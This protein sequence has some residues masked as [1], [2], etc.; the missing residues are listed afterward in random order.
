M[1]NENKIFIIAEAGVNHNGDINLAY[2]LVDNA[3]N[4]GADA[5]K[6]QT[7]KSANLASKFAEKADYQNNN[8][9]SHSQLE[10]LKKLELSFNEFEKLKN[11]CFDKKIIF[12]STP[13]DNESIE[14]LA[15]LD[16]EIFKIPS[17]EL[18]NLPYLRK[19]N[20][21]KKEVI[22]STG[23]ADIKEIEEALKA[24]SLCKKISLLH[25][26]TSYPTPFEHVNLNAMFSLKEMFRL[27]VGYSDHT[28]GIVIPIAAAALGAQIIEK[29]F[30]L[31]KNMEGPDHKASLNPKELYDMVKA[32]RNVE[33]ALGSFEKKITPIE[34][35]NKL[36]ARKSIVAS[37]NILKGE[38]FSE[39]NICAKR[40]GT[41][42][43]PMFWDSVIGKESKRNYYTDE[44]IIDE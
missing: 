35:D 40:P 41:G 39:E 14:Y 32:V 29:H 17:G 5:V 34:I 9:N 13:F 23:M 24:L 10:M 30:T 1:N 21:L 19:I 44:L 20:L 36:V 7:F 6:F 12:M 27:P 42:I 25:C 3:K 33:K 4:A 11:Y 18:T 15:S 8:E 28:K 2:K 43:S 37:K 22:V 38:R 31:D 26:T 16:M